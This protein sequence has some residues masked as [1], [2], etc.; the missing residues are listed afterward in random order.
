[1]FRARALSAIRLAAL[2][3]CT[4]TYAL[5]DLASSQDYQDAVYQVDNQTL[6]NPYDFQFPLLGNAN[7]TALFP[8][9]FCNG[10]T[11]EEATIDQLQDYMSHGRLTAEQ[12][13]RCYMERDYQVD[14][15][16][17]YV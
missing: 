10:I 4:S 13:V 9:R 8:M 15:F 14:E 7:S 17:K 12:I 5:Q 16:C 6:Q 2:L 1:M 11:L 3:C